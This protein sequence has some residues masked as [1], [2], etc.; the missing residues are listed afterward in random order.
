MHPF[1]RFALAFGLL[2]LTT[3]SAF[4]EALHHVELIV[5]RQSADHLLAAYPAP[6]DWAHGA[7]MLAPAQERETTLND[8]AARLDANGGYQV[9]LHR[10]WSQPIGSNASSIAVSTG[11]QRFGHFPTEGVITLGQGRRIDLS[12]ELWVNHFESNGLLSSS[13][14]IRRSVRL[15]SAELTFLDHGNL[16]VLVRVRP[17]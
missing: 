16:G 13:E 15:K 10:A 1:R 3:G 7:P 8:E 11:D 6:E 12:V 5:F 4:A 9:L 17:I 14:L 2:V